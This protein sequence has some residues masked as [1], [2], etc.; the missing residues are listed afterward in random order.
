LVS[1]AT[2]LA[3]GAGEPAALT[4]P[5]TIAI[6]LTRMAPIPPAI[7]GTNLIASMGSLAAMVRKRS[8]YSLM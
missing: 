7:S 1:V 6:T 2:F 4:M 5:T 8:S 3:A